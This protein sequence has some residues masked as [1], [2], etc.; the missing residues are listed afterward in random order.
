MKLIIGLGNPSKKYA[1]TR[2]NVGFMALDFLTPKT[3]WKKSDKAQAQYTKI[4]FGSHRVE[5]LKP[6]TYMNNSGVSVAYAAKKN[7]VL[8]E[9]I[10]VIHDDKD[11]PLGHTK[12]QRDRGSAGHNGIKSIIEHLGTRDFTR[13]RIGVAPPDGSPIEDTANFVLQNFTATEQKI[14]KTVFE[15]VKNEIENLLK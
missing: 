2:H 8:P 4:E 11:I 5:L 1:R 15:N 7:G 12:I 14:L 6:T 10:I 13:I 9:D 3:D